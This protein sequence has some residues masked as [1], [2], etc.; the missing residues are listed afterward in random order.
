MTWHCRN[1][2]DTW[3]FS[4]IVVVRLSGAVMAPLQ[5]LSF[6][7]FIHSRSLC[8]CNLTAA[9]H[10]AE[11]DTHMR[12]VQNRKLQSC[13]PTLWQYAWLPCCYPTAR[14]GLDSS[15]LTPLHVAAFRGD[16]PVP[17]SI[18]GIVYVDLPG[19]CST[20]DCIAIVMSS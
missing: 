7:K 9:S 8:P 11:S 6:H 18:K 5:P 16:N 20:E 10:E 4:A 3:C 17:R 2:W 12:H 15:G 14:N 1:M 19:S 13:Y